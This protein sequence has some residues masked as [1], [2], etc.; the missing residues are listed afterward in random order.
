MGAS[1]YNASRAATMSRPGPVPLWSGEAAPVSAIGSHKQ[2]QPS[3]DGGVEQPI[4]RVITLTGLSGKPVAVPLQEV[5]SGVPAVILSGL[6]GCNSHWDGVT[7]RVSSRVR[8]LSLE[9]PLLDLQGRDCS[10]EGAAVLIRNWAE[11]LGEPAIFIGSS[12][13]GHAALRVAI[14]R[15]D[16]VRALVLT[17]SSGL[18]EKPI[19]GNRASRADRE[20]LEGKIA[21]L[22]F[23]REK[24]SVDDVERAEQALFKDRDKARA[25]IRLSRSCREDYL[26]PALPA[27]EAPT[28]VLWGRQDIVTPPEAAEEFAELIPNAML[29]WLENCGHAPMIEKPVEFCVALNQFLDHLGIP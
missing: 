29:V 28:L 5:G 27:I 9:V 6:V 22:F 19:L 3:V 2:N 17:G 13:G 18:A 8:C 14:E 23:D 4:Q 10:V 16:L 11:T 12:F 25:M 26:G 1:G 7:S 24:M 20:W 21:E 15:P